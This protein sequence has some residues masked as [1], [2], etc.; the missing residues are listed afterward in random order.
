MTVTGG[1]SRT[2][3]CCLVVCS[4]I[5]FSSLPA[6]ANSELCWCGRRGLATTGFGLG[7]SLGARS[8]RTVTAIDR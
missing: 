5:A 2:T 3:G 7:N 4:C 6:A 8:R 1:P